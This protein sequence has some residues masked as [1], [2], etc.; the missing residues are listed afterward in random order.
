MV[1]GV[2]LLVDASEG[3]LPQTRFVLRKALA[4][5]MP[6]VILVN[7]VDRPDA[8]IAAV[9]EETYDLLLDLAADV[10]GIDADKLLEV[11]VVYASAK[12]GRRVLTQPE[13]GGLPDSEDLVPLFQTILD[14]IPAPTYDPETPLQAHVTNLDASPFLGRLALLRVFSGELVKGQTVAWCKHD[15]SMERVRITEL[16]VTEAV[17]RVPGRRPA[18]A[19]SSRSPGSRA[20]PSARPSPT[21]RTRARCRSSPSTSP[22]SRWSSAPTPRRWPAGSRARRSP[23]AWSRTAWSPSSSA[24]CPSASCPPSAPTPGRSRAAVSW[25]WRSSSSRCAARATS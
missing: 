17:S 16:L 14:T 24:T 13:D 20:S 18:P 25:R 9:V 23:R 15:G 10:E 5:G 7:K 19:T 12:N 6:V 22:P 4:A 8:R 21:P 2:V 11:P 1:D 3:P